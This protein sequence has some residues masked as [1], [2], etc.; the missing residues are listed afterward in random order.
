MA[1]YGTELCNS[2][3]IWLGIKALAV[4]GGNTIS[5][6]SILKTL[7]MAKFII[8]LCAFIACAAAKPQFLAPVATPLAAAPVVASVTAAYAAAPIAYANAHLD[9]AYASSSIDVRQNYGAAVV[10]AV[11]SA[12]VAPVAPV[13][14]LKY[15]AAAPV[16]L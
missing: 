13:A 5:I 8:V 4:S 16:L 11:Y 2:R 6:C 1:K 9:A 10:P 15:T 3:R 14:P 12:A 7:K